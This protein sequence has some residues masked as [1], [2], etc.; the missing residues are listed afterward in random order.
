[1]RALPFTH[2]HH[3]VTFPSL[4]VLAT[5]LARA[6]GPGYASFDYEP[7]PDREADV[8]MVSGHD[9]MARSPPAPTRTHPLKPPSLAIRCVLPSQRMVVPPRPPPPLLP[10]RL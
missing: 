7:A 3:P 1:V 6:R 10:H 5:P 8:V 4:V 2:S 9:P